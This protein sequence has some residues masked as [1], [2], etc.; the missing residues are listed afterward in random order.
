M[1]LILE[2]PGRNEVR[3]T[4]FCSLTAWCGW[5]T[6]YRHSSSYNPILAHISQKAV[7]RKAIT[8]FIN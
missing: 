4:Y 2:H 3:T 5:C 8:L 6:D 1:L 7:H